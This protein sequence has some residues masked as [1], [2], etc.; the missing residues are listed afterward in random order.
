MKSRRAFLKN[1][2]AGSLSALVGMAI[3][4]ERNFPEG[5][6]P[7]IL[8]E[9]PLASKHK[10][11]LILSNKPWN[12]EAQPHLLDNAITPAE[13]H[14]VR[15]N[16]HVPEKMEVENWKLEIAGESVLN[17]KTFS[18][19]ELKQSFPTHSYQITLECGGNGRAGF[20]PPASG[21]Q[22]QEGAV[23]CGKW[24]GVRLR[25]VLES[26]GVKQD[27][28]YI[29][30]YGADLHLNGSDEVPISRGVP[31]YKALEEETLLAWAYNDKD[32]PLLNGHP[33]RL[34]VGGWPASVSGKWLKAI[35]VRNK[36]H[37]GPKMEAPSYMVPKIPVAP[38]EKVKE[39]DF[40][41][42]GSMPVKSLVTYPK[43]GAMFPLGTELAVRG[44]AWAGDLVVA[45]MHVSIDF[46]STWQDCIL[47]KPVN[48]FAWQQWSA[49]L[50]FPSKG[51]FEVW[52][53]ATDEKG[54]SQPMLIPGW[55][56]KGYLNNACHRIAVK[57]I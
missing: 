25:D 34:V 28:V 48:R 24:T 22:W 30:Y 49:S 38:G 1:A 16:G 53:K 20:Y 51:Y 12:I 52:A 13:V 31:M 56:P 37:D 4:F 35:H 7:I 27:A 40:E 10:D 9:D 57:V 47:N 15:N 33:L 5:L 36:V 45:K 14:F 29:G 18:L 19:K 8:E 11:M 50:N 54:R 39:E 3:P 32:I 55:N 17:P 26:V 42:I 44:H 43:S 6:L 46:G 21:N 23:A 2:T 41:I